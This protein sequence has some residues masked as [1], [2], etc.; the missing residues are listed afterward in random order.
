[1]A[2]KVK[3]L[4]FCLSIV[5]G[6]ILLGACIHPA[7]NI[8]LVSSPATAGLVPVSA[9][10]VPRARG[11]APGE[12]GLS[13]LPKDSIHT[14]EDLAV[15]SIAP[16]DEPV[17]TP[18]EVFIAAV[19][20]E[21]NSITG[22][23]VPGKLAL[24]VLQ[25]PENDPTYVSSIEGVVTQFIQ[26]AQVNNIG[27]LAHNYASGRAFFNLTEGDLVNIIYGDGQIEAFSVH[28]IHR[29]QALQPDNPKG[30]F[31]NLEDGQ[32]LAA[33][34]LFQKVYGGDR[35]VTFQTCL[36]NGNDISWGRIF[37]IATP[38]APAP[39]AALP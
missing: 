21:P 10:A 27:L 23:Y 33:G 17:V 5:L 20:G 25:Q 9:Q 2:S 1:M 19:A 31:I 26:A 7:G 36:Q 38:V 12:V 11:V 35:H 22:V 14:D 6:A 29:Y 4:S 24:R 37:I 28:E 32:V 3:F 8:P 39:F 15:T 13:P 18:L 34:Q 16:A 30:D